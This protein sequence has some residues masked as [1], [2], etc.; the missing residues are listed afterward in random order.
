MKKQNNVSQK[1]NIQVSDKPSNL[2]QDRDIPADAIAIIGTAFRLPGACADADALWQAF[3]DKKD[4]ITRI[5]SQRWAVDELEHSDRA[6]PGRSITFDAGVVDDVG[7]FDAA[8]FGI[9]P[10]EAAW[11]DPQQRLLLELSWEA[12]ENSGIAPATLAGSNTA[13]YVGI[14]SLDYGTRGLDDLAALNANL[15]TGN[16]LSVAANRLSYFYDLHG[17]SLAVD[18]ACSSSLVA[19]HHACEAIRSGQ[20]SCALAAGVSLLL[21]P[22]PFVG[23][24]KASMLSANGRCRSF[25]A[26]GDGY[27]RSEGGGVAVLKPY[28]QALADGDSI[29]AVILASGVNADGR[30]KTGITIPSFEGQTELMRQ[31][32]ARS[33]LQPHEIDFV[34]AHGTG[35]PV[36]DPIEA[37]AIGRVYGQSRSKPLPIGAVKS[38]LGHLEAGAGMAGLVKAILTLKH[39]EMPGIVHLETPNP[40]IDFEA[41]NLSLPQTCVPIEQ[42]LDRPLVGAV[43][44]F[45]FGGVNAHVILQ[46][47]Q[48]AGSEVAKTKVDVAAA[49]S[50]VEPLFISAR[51][52]QALQAMALRYADKLGTMAD[53]QARNDL[54]R[55]AALNRQWLDNRLVVTAPSWVALQTRLRAFSQD[56]QSDGIVTETVVGEELDSANSIAFVYGGNG[57]QWQG[58]G[59]KLL[60][61][62]ET[63]KNC[64][65][66]LDSKMSP[67]V[68]FSVLESLQLKPA[69]SLL[70]DTTVAQ[71]LLFAIQVA[72]TQVLHEQGI[73]PSAVTG[74][75]VGEIAAAWACGALTLEQAI[76]VIYVRSQAQGLTRGQGR[77]AA[78]ALSE[79][80]LIG[81]LQDLG[82]AHDIEIAGFNS[83]NHLTI[84]G[85]LQYL[86]RLETLLKEKQVFCQ[87]LDLDYAFHSQRMD[88]VEGQILQ[89]LKDLTSSHELQA[90]FVSTVEGAAIANP[91]LDAQYWWRNIREPV[92]FQDAI[93][94]M[95]EDG[96]RIFVE[97]GP[98]AILQRYIRDVIDSTEIDARVLPT[99]RRGR[100]RLNDLQET[101]SRIWLLAPQTVLDSW[102]V[103]AQS[104]VTLPNYPWQ[105]ERYWHPVT[106]ESL[107]AI[108]RRR[109]HP[110][111][112]WPLYGDQAAW[113]NVLD[114]VQFPWLSDHQVGG[115]VVLPGAAYAEMALAAGRQW[116]DGQIVWLEDLEIL[117]PMV[118]DGHHAR[119]VRLVVDE[120]DGVFRITSR[121]RLSDD[122]WVLHAI[123]RLLQP[124]EHMPSAQI[125]KQIDQSAKSIDHDTHYDLVREFGLEYGPVFRGLHRIQAHADGF[126]ASIRSQK[127]LVQDLTQSDY[128]LHP[129]FLDLCFQALVHSVQAQGVTAAADWVF[130]PVRVGRLERFHL[131]QP[132][133]LRARIVKRGPRSILADFELFDQHD[134]LVARASG[135]RFRAVRLNARI[136]ADRDARWVVSSRLHPHALSQTD[137]VRRPVEELIKA[138]N[139][140][141]EPIALSRERWFTELLPLAEMLMLAFTYEA[142]QAAWASDELS[143]SGWMAVYD[144]EQTIPLIRWLEELLREEGLLDIRNGTAFL[145]QN[146][147]LPQAQ[148]IWQTLLQ[149]YPEFMPQLTL[150]GHWG[151]ALP[152]LLRGE[153]SAE[154]LYEALRTSPI[155]AGLYEDDPSNLGIRLSLEATLETLATTLPQDRRLRVLELSAEP[156][157]LPDVLIRHLDDDRYEYVLG[158]TDAGLESTLHAYYQAQHAVSVYQLD[159]QTPEALF[160][161]NLGQF[162]LVILRHTLHRMSESQAV[163]EQIQ[164]RMAANG[165]LVVAE[166]YPDWSAHFLHGLESNW[167]LRAQQDGTMVAASVVSPLCVPQTWQTLLTDS[168][169]TV[170]SLYEEPTSG[171]LSEG[172]FLIFANASSQATDPMPLVCA[173]QQAQSWVLM[174][175]EETHSWAQQLSER[176]QAN[177]QYVSIEL[178]EFKAVDANHVVFLRG[179]HQSMEKTSDT[180]NELIALVQQLSRQTQALGNQVVPS[181]LWIVTR[182]AVLA[183]PVQASGDG[184][185]GQAALWGV[186]RVLMNEMSALNPTLID[187]GKDDSELNT[188][189]DRLVNE[190]MHPDQANEILCLAQGRYVPVLHPL[191][192][193]ETNSHLATQT[194]NDA[195]RFRL[196]FLVPGKL[197]NL[198]WLANPEKTLEAHEVEVQ[199]HAVGL[200]FRDIMY[201][202]GLLPDEAVEDGFAGASLGLEMAGVISRV[203]SDV[204]GM[205]VGDA[206]MGFGP[207]CFSSHVVTREDAL[208]QIPE[209]WSFES[210][211]TVPTVFFTAYYA[212]AHLAQVEPGERVLIH[213][214]A[215]GVGIAAI[216]I[217]RHLGAEIFATA[218]T[219]E[220]RDFVRLLGADHVFDTRSLDFADEILTLTQGQGVDVVLNSLAGEAM[221]RSLDVLKPFGRFL[222]L[223]KRDFYENTAIGLR[224]MRHNISYFGIDADQLLNGRP[225]LAE[226]LFKKVM[227]LFEQGVLNPLPYRAFE[228]TEV[229]DAF[230]VMQQAHHIGKIV[231]SLKDAN[232]TLSDMD[233]MIPEASQPAFDSQ[234]TWLVTGGL[235]GFGLETARW[236]TQHG[237]RYLTLVGRRGLDTPDVETVLEEFSEQGVQVQVLACDVSDAQSVISTLQAVRADMP[238][239][240]GVIHAAAVFADRLVMDMD[241]QHMQTVLNA[242]LLGAWNLHEATLEDGLEH[243]VLYSSVT[244]AIGNPGQSNYVAANLG[245]ETLSDLRRAEGLPVTCLAWG[246]IGD[247]GYLTREQAVRNSLEQRLGRAP[248]SSEQALRALGSALEN[249]PKRTII[250]GDFDWNV[251]SRLLPSAQSLRFELLNRDRKEQVSD[252][253]DLDALL[254]G[255]TPEQM[256]IVV[257]DYVAREVA[258]TLSMPVDR[259]DLQRSLHDLGMDSLMAVELAVGLEQRFKLQLPVMMLNDSPT[260]VNVSQRILEK[261][262]T[263][264][265]D[266]SLDDDAQKISGLLDQH[267]VELTQ[268][269]LEALDQ[270]ARQLATDG[271]KLIE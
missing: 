68:G 184:L 75:S 157:Q 144:D 265:S 57:A 247:A 115:A 152:K 118:W 263:R 211:A 58:M 33:G 29:E 210:A 23:F 188:D 97:I 149:Q 84:S 192:E 170:E 63:F 65:V 14:S 87:I 140:R 62:S 77:M 102:K 47:P 237:V 138:I 36:G 37:A 250:V 251:L 161:T 233:P 206:V 151:L 147:E 86:Q 217:A 44:S 125:A 16:T 260:V 94:C 155:Y 236:L 183:E 31:V 199:T 64:L 121:L 218:G 90:T 252:E 32:L 61:E 239:L 185:P 182:E 6:E 203:G 49:E 129:G 270:A 40:N 135:C 89:Q 212:L 85:S 209:D 46:A 18:T 38:N 30:R 223:G 215:G 165:Q 81:I 216:Q 198:L 256:L 156:S 92:K 131:E 201:L 59:L 123:G 51:S 235:S 27:V 241:A 169:F 255:K 98:H 266:S 53:D 7:E 56:E 105:K 28:A 243:F 189:L 130:L 78:V 110:L 214:A 43:N 96:N 103:D 193:S 202:L 268:D 168:G 5:P 227:A 242:K 134:R 173:A 22:Y 34:E 220:K 13:V 142:F 146:A 80:E 219:P 150:M 17:P 35:T 229:V 137:A 167:W 108:T 69:E 127:A 171:E 12:L 213:G 226:K 126:S 160:D 154:A 111:L 113:E 231:V 117:A 159:L 224:V 207:A 50:A 119:T 82:D 179:W 267:G 248:L 21:H 194:E 25:D 172:G 153:L 52:T 104:S 257:Q 20:A 2:T 91:S 200:N 11:M 72:I 42:P 264:S 9:S 269:E 141:L 234:S 139:T 197:R 145:D 15:M 8:F 174:A 48:V 39:K 41:L 67:V 136:Q 259:I 222:E 177:G 166:R 107:H 1:P 109:V 271:T 83:P 196:D 74:H 26:A 24:T 261:L 93:S 45:G 101:C 195:S 133:H 164:A 112:G 4:L 73:V 249:D 70:E 10:R 262:L 19:L 71:P 246:P 180:A 254:Q 3:R 245:L 132:T 55:S 221:R 128:V 106:N 99:L 244:T 258:Q 54:V 175:D 204:Q 186:G 163:L 148:A 253:Q 76:E 120:D 95:V 238:P 79:V 190:L 122:D 178:D 143:E 230:R 240:C 191:D 100:D 66:E 158:V 205:K 114:P 176:L 187:L 60:E 232:P 116:Y 181:R 124:S 228:A 208:V 225:A 162:D 88:P